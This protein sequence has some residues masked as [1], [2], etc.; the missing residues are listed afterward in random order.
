MV[1]LGNTHASGACGRKPLEVRVLS[2]AFSGPEIGRPVAKIAANLPLSSRGLGRRILSPET[3]VRIP[4]AVPQ[5]PASQAGFVVREASA[6]Q[7]TGQ[8]SAQKTIADRAIA[9]PKLPPA[10]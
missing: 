4:V 9:A 6:G 1:K 2:A 3:G 10:G 7:L 5:K 8:C